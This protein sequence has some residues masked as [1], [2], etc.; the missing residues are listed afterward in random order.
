MV[1]LLAYLRATGSSQIYPRGML[2]I[3]IPLC[4]SRASNSS[5]D[6]QRTDPGAG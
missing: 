6:S 1:N 3:M 5:A 2:V 4:D